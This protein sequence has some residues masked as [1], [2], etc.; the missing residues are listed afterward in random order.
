MSTTD[1]RRI[2]LFFS[3]RQHAGEN[4][5][6]V[7]AHRSATLTPPIQMCDALSHNLPAGLKTILANCLAHGRRQFVEVAERFPD[8]CRY[9][10]EML[11]EVYKNDA[12]AHEQKLS[13]EARLSFHQARS[14]PIMEGLQ[15]WCIQTAFGFVHRAAAILDNPREQRGSAVRRRYRAF[16]RNVAG[17]T[18][19]AGKLQAA[20]RHFLKVTRSYWPGLFHC[21]DVPDLPRTNNGLEQLFGS[22]RHHERRCTFSQGRVAQFGAAGLRPHHGWLGHTHALLGRPPVG[23]DEHPGMARLAR[24]P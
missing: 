11:A 10:L 2:A 21:Y 6:D 3:G 15:A 7:L 8:E 9:V 14:S 24:Q 18:K 12:I 13:P 5:A 17:A 19:R 4:L 23:A 20:L 16:L 22:T 1:G